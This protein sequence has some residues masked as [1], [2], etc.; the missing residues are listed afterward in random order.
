MHVHI[1]VTDDFNKLSVRNVFTAFLALNLQLIK[2]SHVLDNYIILLQHFVDHT[3][4]QR[5]LHLKWLFLK[6]NVYFIF[7]KCFIHLTLI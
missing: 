6:L 1:Y 7:K 3:C 2:Q 4:A 5:R